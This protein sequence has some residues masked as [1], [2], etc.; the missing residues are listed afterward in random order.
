[1]IMVMIRSGG[2]KGEEVGGGKA[3]RE[4]IISIYCQA[5]SLA[6]SMF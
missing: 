6:L 4:E 2:R 1:M 3:R 5:L